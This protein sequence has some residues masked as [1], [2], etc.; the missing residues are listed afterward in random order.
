MQEVISDSGLWVRIVDASDDATP[1]I[2]QF[3]WADAVP[4]VGH[5]IEHE[6]ASLE[7]VEVRWST[8]DPGS[9]TFRIRR[10]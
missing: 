2:G 8:A 6:G 7:V 10:P 1:P 3:R 5:V 9:V 4:Q